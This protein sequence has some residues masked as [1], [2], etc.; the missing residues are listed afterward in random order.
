VALGLLMDYLL[1][2]T[3]RAPAFG[4]IAG[5]EMRY[6]TE[7]SLY[8]ALGI[9]LAF[10]PLRLAIEPS[11]PRDVALLRVH[12]TPVI[13]VLLTTMVVIGSLAST[14]AYVRTWHT[15][16]PGRSYLATVAQAGRDLG[17][18]DLV[19][20]RV[21][22]EVMSPV[23]APY[24]T[25]GRL[26]PMHVSDVDLPPVST[27]LYVLDDQGVPRPAQIDV[28]TTSPRGTADGC[29]WR[30]GPSGRTIPL[31][32]STLDYD[33]WMRVGYLSSQRTEVTVT[34]GD[35]SRQAVLNPGIGSLFVQAT[36]A[37]DEVRI[38]GLA[39]E[40]TLCVD[41]IEVGTAVPGAP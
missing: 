38:S 17:R 30:V 10:L 27:N 13:P 33:W 31:T 39:A 11:R 6:V 8:V 12:V 15:D 21:P 9:G 41:V 34:A 37:F 7:A 4:A 36:G 26:V 2:L 5:N 28:A 22:D 14:F 1:L 19:D 23:Q 3:T 35:V 20:A 32:T 18:L 24:N 25:V 16:N 40:T 29:G